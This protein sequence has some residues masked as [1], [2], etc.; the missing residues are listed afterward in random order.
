MDTAFYRRIPW[1]YEAIEISKLIAARAN[2]TLDL[3][4]KWVADAIFAGRL[5]FPN[6]VPAVQVN[7]LPGVPRLGAARDYLMRGPRGEL[8]VCPPE[9]L[10]DQ[11]ELIE[12]PIDRIHAIKD[13]PD[14]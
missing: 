4:P 3:A 2:G 11:F 7:V 1:E 14:G 9:T 5:E 8:S 13:R 12:S 6:T 10:A